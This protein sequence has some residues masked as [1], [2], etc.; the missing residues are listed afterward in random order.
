MGR[1]WHEQLGQE[2]DMI[3]EHHGERGTL[4]Q[5][6]GGAERTA[7]LLQDRTQLGCGNT[8]LGSQRLGGL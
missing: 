4:G 1:E 3:K 5:R 2:V 6:K 7:W 8:C